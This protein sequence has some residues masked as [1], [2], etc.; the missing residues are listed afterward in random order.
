MNESPL[1]SVESVTHQAWFRL[2]IIGTGALLA[3]LELSLLVGCQRSIDASAELDR[4]QR[5]HQSSLVEKLFD[6]ALGLLDDPEQ[7]TS[8]ELLA[9]VVNRLNQWVES[10]EHLPDWR[11]DPL[12]ATL[13]EALQKSAAIQSLDQLKFISGDG[14][15]LQEAQWLRDTAR[16]VAQGHKTD[17]DK[18]LALLDWTTRNIALLDESTTDRPPRLAWEVLIH[19]RGTLAERV[20]IFL[21]LARQQGLSAVVLLPESQREAPRQVGIFLDGQ[22]ALFDVA[23]G[24][25]LRRADG[26]GFATLADVAANAELLRQWSLDDHPYPIEAAELQQLTLGV[27]SSP[28]YFAERFRHVELR[29]SGEQRMVLSADAA[30]CAA[31]LKK[32]PQVKAVT[33]WTLPL[34]RITRRQQASRA[35]MTK[36]LDELRPYH[37]PAPFLWT[38][39]VLQLRGQVLGEVGASRAYQSSRPAKD[40]LDQ[41]ELGKVDR[42]RIDF[43]KQQA[44]YWLGVIALERGNLDT[45]LEYLDERYARIYPASPWK[46]HAQF[47]LAEV[48]LRQGKQAEAI[49]AYH[50]VAGLERP[51]ALLRAQAVQRSAP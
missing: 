30:G 35:E 34:E 37:E 49:A 23:L 45:A 2:W 47:L 19:G 10:R 22:L 28:Q 31:Q 43:A 14:W 15:A 11:R 6:N 51:A 33:F 29:L 3:V 48:W 20:W 42:D 36:V 4:R 9:D 24:L 1:A 16:H 13:P 27:E 5:A 50:Q 32:L 8:R 26:Q 12:L 44:T 25:P 18:A 40:R 41:L 38:G 39:R 7:I 21:L 17:A 46:P